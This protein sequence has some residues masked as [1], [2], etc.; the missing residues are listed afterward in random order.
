MRNVIT[1]GTF[2]VFHVGHLN[3]LKRAK[4]FGDKLIVGVSSDAL[5]VKKKDRYPIYN[6]TD[7]LSIIEGIKY[8]D[9]VFLEESLELKAEYITRYSADVLVMGD[10]WQGRFDY[11][12]SLVKVVYLERTPSVSTTSVIEVIQHARIRTPITA[13]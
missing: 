2:D 10:D 3:I 11:L 6:E 1:F 13:C 4:S 7:R 12:S 9:E 8:V 5:N